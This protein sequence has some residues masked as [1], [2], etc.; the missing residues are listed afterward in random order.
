LK[1]VTRRPLSALVARVSDVR[2]AKEG[3]SLDAQV[4]LLKQFA[5]REGY[6]TEDRYI[7]FD[8]GYQGDDWNRPAINKALSL[9]QSGE[10]QAVTFLNTDRFARDVVGGRNMV[11]KLLATGAAVIFGDLGKVR[12]DANFMLMLTFKLGLAEYEKAMIR[13]RSTWGTLQKIKGG[14]VICAKPIYGYER[15]EDNLRILETEAKIVRLIFRLYDEG[16]AGEAYSIRA[17]V[18]RLKADGVLPPGATRGKLRKGNWNPTTISELL[19]D[20]TYIGEWHYGKTQY[21]E[22]KKRRS[23]KE[24]HRPKSSKRH[25]PP[26]E[27]K[28]V[29]VDAI[30]DKALF[31]RVQAKL[32]GNVHVLGGRP[33]TVNHYELKGLLFC[34]RCGRPYGGSAHRGVRYCCSWRNRDTGAN[35]CPALSVRADLIEPVIYGAVEELLTQKEVLAEAIGKLQKASTSQAKR[36]NLIARSEE[37]RRLEFK[38]RREKLHAADDEETVKFYEQ[39][40]KEIVAQR[41]QIQR[42]IDAMMPAIASIDAEAILRAAKKAFATKDRAKRQQILRQFVK[43]ITYDDRDQTVEIQVAIPMKTEKYCKSRLAELDSILLIPIK[44]RVA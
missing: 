41:S 31:E 34:A 6:A 27:W 24:V 37:M 5:E 13:T 20:R 15:W 35:N 10:V 14:E 3:Y 17:I 4:P 28:L 33:A 42:Q 18:R 32:L 29:E 9:A 16:E 36:D 19:R 11:A 38:A 12:D 7:L 21:V 26:S 44:R 39:E 40:I 1:V 8:D 2:A 43:R 25:L 30:V 22:P 23:T